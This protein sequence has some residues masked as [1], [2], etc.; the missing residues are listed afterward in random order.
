[1]RTVLFLE[2]LLQR[3]KVFFEIPIISDFIDE[4]CN[5]AQVD[6]FEFVKMQRSLFVKELTVGG[7]KNSLFIEAL[8]VLDGVKKLTELRKSY[9][10]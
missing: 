3:S 5:I 1:M 4:V 7:V 9:Y 8:N 2:N 10:Y 6:K